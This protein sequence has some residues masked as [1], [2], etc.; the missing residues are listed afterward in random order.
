MSGRNRLERNSTNCRCKEILK[1]KWIKSEG[2]GRDLGDEAVLDW[3][4][5]YAHEFRR[6]WEKRLRGGND[7][8]SSED[9]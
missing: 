1:H 4:K 9:E 8:A 5:K 3:I 2:E 7:K 6:Y